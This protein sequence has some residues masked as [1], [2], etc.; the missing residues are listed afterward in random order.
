[1]SQPVDQ[2][3]RRIASGDP[4][5]F[6]EYYRR[7]FDRMYRRARSTCRRDESFCLDVVQDAMLKAMRRMRPIET[8]AALGAWTDALVRS[9][10]V[11]RIRSD[12]R[13]RMR[14]ETAARRRSETG[15]APAG[16]GPAWIEARLE[17]LDAE[18]VQLIVRRFRFGW[19]LQRI[20][21]SLGLGAGA[22]DGRIRRA[23]AALRRSAGEVSDDR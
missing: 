12:L 7:Y 17:G 4:E 18:Q 5:A 1:M 21:E 23:L 9:C 2:L 6:A 8:E 14:E 15:P 13:R 20:G 16:I 11:D 19:T 22:V 3:T 10:A